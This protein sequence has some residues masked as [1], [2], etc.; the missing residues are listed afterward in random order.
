MQEKILKNIRCDWISQNQAWRSLSILEDRKLGFVFADVNCRLV[1]FIEGKY[2]Y[3]KD[4]HGLMDIIG[5]IGDNE[6]PNEDNESVSS[7]GTTV[8]DDAHEVLATE[9]D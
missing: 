8:G 3:P 1:A 4:E 5:K 9:E 7:E 2:Y 6:D